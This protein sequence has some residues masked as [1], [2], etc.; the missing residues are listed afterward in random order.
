MVDNF[1]RFAEPVKLK[2]DKRVV[3][4]EVRPIIADCTGSIWVTDVQFQEGEKLTGYTQ[5]STTMLTESG[6]QPRFQNGVIRSG[7]TAILFNTG[8]TTAGLDIYLYPNAAMPAGA[9]EVAQGAGSHRCRF[10]AAANPGDEFAL[11]A[12][13]REC[14]RNGQ[15]TPKSGFFQDVAAYDSKHQV[16]VEPHKSARVLMEYTE[17]MESEVTQ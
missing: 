8:G 12:E 6:N 17:M 11:L 2:S 14:H 7:A 1:I 15:P 4:V 13:R 3:A 10:K 16:K 9:I 5:Y